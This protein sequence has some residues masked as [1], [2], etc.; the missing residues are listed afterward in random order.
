LDDTINITKLNMD[1]MTNGKFNHE[2]KDWDDSDYVNKISEYGRQEL[3]AKR[4][5]KTKEYNS[6]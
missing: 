2:F 6:I 1:L 3:K 5:G 4:F